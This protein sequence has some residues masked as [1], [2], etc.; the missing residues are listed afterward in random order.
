MQRSALYGGFAEVARRLSDAGPRR[1]SRQGV[2]AW[3]LSSD[4]NGFP[5]F[6]HLDEDG[7][8]VWD[9]SEVV[10]WYAR[11]VPPPTSHWGRGGK[12]KE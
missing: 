11:Y 9:I 2:R 7:F 6:D 4:R 3:F 1:V 5:E 8:R 12:K 10:S